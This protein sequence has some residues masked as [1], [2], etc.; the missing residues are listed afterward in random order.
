MPRRDDIKK[1]LIIGSGP[2]V[3]GQACE[4]DYSG[5]QACKALREEGYE[6]VLVNSNPATIMTDPQMADATYIEP[7][8]IES[9]EKIIAKER[10][11]ALLPTLGGQVGLNLGTFL[12][13]EGILKKYNV[14]M[15]G[16]KAESIAKAED[17]KLFK[18]TMESIGV[19]TPKSG[20]AETMDEG[21]SII[22]EIGFPVIL[23][24]A[25]TMGGAGGGTAYNMEE[26]EKMLQKALETSPVHQTLIE[27][28]VIGWKE[29]EF[30]VMRDS[31]D[32]VII[33][34][35]MEN[36]DPMGVH[37]GDSI[38]VAPALTLTNDE[39]VKL[40]DIAKKIIRAIN[41]TGGGTNV[42]LGVNPING[43]VVIIEINPRVSRSSALASKATGFPIA[44]V[45]AKLAVGYRF[46]EIKN[47][48]TGKTMS[49][50]EPAIDYVVMKVCRFAFE[51]FAGADPTLTTQMKAV[52]ES[53]AIGRNFKESIQK[54]IRSLEIGRYGLGSDGKDYCPKTG[55]DIDLI[56]AKISQPNAL[57]LFYIKHG[58]E[59]GLTIDKIND[60]CK[61]DKW[62][63]NEIKQLVDF[64]KSIEKDNID[65]ISK[66]NLKKAKEWG[67][68]DIQLAYL[69]KSDEMSI[70]AKREELGIISTYYEVDTCAGEIEAQKPYYYSTYETFDQCNAT[71][72][73]K[74][75]IILGGGPN[76]IG[77][78][79]EFD[80]CCVHASYA[81]KEAGYE[82]I[83]INCNPET[84]ST[85][86]DTS[87]K[88]YFEP[89]TREDVLNIIEKEKPYGVIVQLGG[90]T[91]LNLSAH[92]KAEGVN[93]LGTS[94]E[95]IDLAEDR[96]LFSK[97]LDKL[98][99]RQTLNETATNVEEALDAAHRI[100]YPLLVRPSYVLGGRA[101]EIVYDD[102]TL[103]TYMKTAVIA[104]PER[105]VLVDK[106]LDD[107]IE[108]DVDAIS[109]GET[110][111]VCGVMEH[112]EYAGVHSGDSACSLPTWSLKRN[113]VDE[114]KRQTYLLAK[115]LNVRGLMNIQF[116]V[117]D[118]IVYIIEV[119][120]RASRT[121]PFVSKATGKPWAKIATRIMLGISLKEQGITSE[122]T[123]THVCVKEA[124]FPFVK[125]PGIDCMLGPEMKSTGEVMGIDNNFGIAYLKAQ[126]AAGNK[127]PQGGNCF[128]SLADKDQIHTLDIAKKL[129]KL[130]FKIYATHGTREAIIDEI[131][132][133][134]LVNKIE[135]GRPDPIDYIK[136]GDFDMII[137]TPSGRRPKEH[138]VQMRATAI[139]RNVP[140]ITTL[141]AA[142]ATIIG[143][144]AQKNNRFGC[145]SL[146][147]YTN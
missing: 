106:F 46:D 14:E 54:G 116:A 58:L 6:V 68:S 65:T 8:T 77:Q 132:D 92:L 111:L 34:T 115:E 108:V 56:K 53:M 79:I 133:V 42:Q 125:F 39:L 23:R 81:L 128:L 139:A 131:S 22:K 84:V 7:L 32:N 107:A 13:R 130:G 15:L 113:I 30:E 50:F 36:I 4:F 90:Q 24:P 43:D 123:P 82:A 105:P 20:I 3:I 69:L 137:N 33:I 104:S 18:E 48:I 117:K 122:V 10:P 136:N 124:V 59:N 47:D 62:F 76:R 37:T 52:G 119:N 29:V 118:D 101:M 35:S 86:F 134:V 38:V 66:E 1:I 103:I 19:R 138:E 75:V 31:A 9:L 5:S 63:L 126:I 27:E 60:I 78:G 146:Q 67:Y 98:G 100:G 121:V 99:L 49:N 45:A 28:S 88:L 57:R 129:V 44:R 61:I 70:R 51:K 80:Y 135:M 93:I 140:I 64:E 91:P 144:E 26:Y 89:L 73:K 40:A 143:L 95:S 17:R 55:A 145:K 83:I 41:V 147:E 109:D 12:E 71:D 87:D 85:D 96:K 127:I 110:T 72:N 25:F 114:I 112:I 16:C 141:A 11:D 74:K 2:I 94:P 21:M 120:P 142:Y 102:T 97:M